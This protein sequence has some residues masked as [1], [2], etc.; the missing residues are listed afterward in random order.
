MSGRIV[1]LVSYFCLDFRLEAEH[2]KCVAQRIPIVLADYLSGGTIAYLGL[3]NADLLDL[4]LGDYAPVPDSD[5]EFSASGM[6][7]IGK[8]I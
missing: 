2:G 1:D 3:Y 5:E 4:S 8:D 6:I 7:W